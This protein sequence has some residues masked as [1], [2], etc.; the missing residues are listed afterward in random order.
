VL[1]D[2][3]GAN[4]VADIACA[5]GDLSFFLEA[6]G[7]KVQ[8]FD[9]PITNHNAMRGI[10]ALK[11]ALGSEVEIF[12]CDLDSQFVLPRPT[13]DLAFLLGALYHLKNPFYVLEALSK[14]AAYCLISTR[15]AALTPDKTFSFRHLP[16]AY[17]VGESELNNDNSNYW[18]FSEA[19]LRR[20]FDRTNWDVLD[21]LSTGATGSSDP[22]QAD[23]RVFCLLRSRYGISNV[24]LV[25][26]WHGVEAAGWRWTE[27]IFVAGARSADRELSNLK[28][29]FY[30]PPALV[31]RWGSI[32]L[33]ATV[34]GESLPPET[35]TQDGE[36]DFVRRFSPA[37]SVT[38]KFE[39]DHALPPDS[40]DARERG[41]IVASLTID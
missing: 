30:L 29:R 18:I 10:R 2:R 15:V 13:Y 4:P 31:E 8:A 3:I 7:C 26:G 16:V 38:V 20:L 1:L 33:G 25:Q 34:N 32:A 24:E 37:K 35:Y 36:Q 14:Q 21:Y 23:E 5:D 12:N 17:L 6:C 39:V 9:W 40:S 11:S 27:R 19:G 41:V 28:L 22:V